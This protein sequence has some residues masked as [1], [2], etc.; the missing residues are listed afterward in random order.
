[1]VINKQILNTIKEKGNQRI[2]I[3]QECKV[4]H[5]TYRI[6]IDPKNLN[7]EQ[8][9]GLKDLEDLKDVEGNILL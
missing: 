9:K 8:V 3:T 5:K 2:V 6:Y 7:L 4:H 1:M